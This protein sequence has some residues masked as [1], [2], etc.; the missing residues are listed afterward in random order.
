[1]R[2]DAERLRVALQLLDDGAAVDLHVDTFIG[3]RL[4]G[5]D[6]SREHHP[7]ARHFLGHVDLPRARRGGLKGALWS[8]TT[9]P[10]RCASSR[11]RHAGQNVAR[12]RRFATE[13]HG[14]AWVTDAAAFDAAIARGDHA[15][16]PVVQGA[17]GIGDAADFEGAGCGDVVSATLVHLLSSRYGETSTP[18]PWR[19]LFGPVGL[20]RAGRALLETMNQARMLVDLAH[21]STEMFWDTVAAHDR[22]QPLAV[23][24]TG[25]GGVYP[26]WRNI[27]DSQLRAVAD[28]GGIVGVIFHPGFLGPASEHHDGLGLVMRHLSHIVDVVGEDHAA[29]GSDWDGF[30]VPPRALN[31]PL[32]LPALVMEMVARGWSETRVHKVLGGNFLRCF[33][34]LRPGTPQAP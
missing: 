22:S 7:I 10:F 14:A 26:H 17:N 33:R 31:S 11:R 19:G 24:H 6:A 9:N 32:G 34:A 3:A 21:S 2:T 25:L 1:M 30:I 23:T 13:S 18:L 8:V 29:L 16:I 15:V 28:T 12:L 5:Y 4:F 20:S 27:D